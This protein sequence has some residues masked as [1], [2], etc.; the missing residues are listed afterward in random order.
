MSTKRQEA[1]IDISLIKMDRYPINPTTLSLI[2]YLRQGKEAPAIKVSRLSKG[3][4]KIK[5]G[6]H[7]VL[8]YKL[9]GRT[10][11]KAAFSTKFL[12]Y[13]SKVNN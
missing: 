7:R 2:D 10:K 4:Y 3:G 11:I 12:Q 1:D 8:A 13:P 9:L 5:D 6:R